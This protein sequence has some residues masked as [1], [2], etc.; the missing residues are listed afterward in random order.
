[1]D[2]RLLE[3]W[4]RV[5]SVLSAGTAVSVTP[6]LLPDKDRA[7]RFL[8]RRPPH[9]LASISALRDGL[10]AA[11]RSAEILAI[12][13]F[14]HRKDGG[15]QG[16]VAA[17]LT[18]AIGGDISVEGRRERSTFASLCPAGHLPHR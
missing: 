2:G 15:E 8:C 1:M 13:L 18:A 3:I 5:S 4:Q 7:P 14:P 11:V 16:T 6:T 10:I 9:R 17:R 12:H